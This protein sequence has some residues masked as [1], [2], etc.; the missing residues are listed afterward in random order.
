MHYVLVTASNLKMLKLIMLKP[1]SL[2]LKP[3]DFH[4]G[5]SHVSGHKVSDLNIRNVNFS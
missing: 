2:G 5:F 4:Y 3:M 1:Y